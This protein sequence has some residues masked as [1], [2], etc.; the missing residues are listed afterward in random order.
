MFAR[1]ALAECS[2]GS[3][4]TPTPSAARARRPRQR[5]VAH[6]ASEVPL[7][8]AETRVLPPI[9]SGQN[10]VNGPDA[11]G[12]SAASESFPGPEHVEPSSKHALHIPFITSWQEVAP[13]GPSAV[14]GPE[15]LSG[16][17]SNDP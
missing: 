11:T 2:D 16:R 5:R 1:L 10:I 12:E 15:W 13:P 3:A 7:T 9:T 4:Q 14:N 6:Y 17:S 8:A